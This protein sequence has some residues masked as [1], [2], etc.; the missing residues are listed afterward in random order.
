ME[1]KQYPKW[2]VEWI[3]NLKDVKEFR[4][5]TLVCLTWMRPSWKLH[6]WH[7]KGALENWL[8]LQKEDSIENNFLIADYQ[9]LW[10][11]LWKKEQLRSSVKNMV[12]DWLA[13][14]LN[15]E[16][17]NFIVQSYVP[18]YDTLFNL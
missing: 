7:F 9:A 13:V 6:L 3:G 14:W 8:A 2:A 11:H 16:K 17:S 5:D 4:Q 1:A 12:I 18:E 10:D 15:P